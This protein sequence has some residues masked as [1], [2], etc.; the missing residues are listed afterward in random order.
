[1]RITR[2][3]IC[4]VFINIL[5][6]C[7][8]QTNKEKMIITSNKVIEAIRT[9][10]INTF[11]KLIGVS[12]LNVIGKDDEM[13]EYDV[14]KYKN[15]FEKYISGK[16]LQITITD[17]YNYLGQRIVKIPIY[18]N[19]QDSTQ[20]KEIHLNLYFGPPNIKPLNKISG[21]E[22]IKNSMDPSDFRL[23]HGNAEKKDFFN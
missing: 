1:M 6:G 2:I 12:E 3:A 4:L 17:L 21:Y 9:E 11:K 19:P 10:D 5:I 7:K 20:I 15:L 16:E 18:E 22:L 8:A 23:I 13:I 14:K